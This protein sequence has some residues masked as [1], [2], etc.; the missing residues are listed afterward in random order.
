MRYWAYNRKTGRKVQIVTEDEKSYFESNPS[1]NVFRYVPI[2][3]PPPAE[4]PQE[5]KAAEK[6]EAPAEKA[7]KRQKGKTTGNDTNK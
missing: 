6:A 2:T 4:R 3:A 5:V 1:T 7:T